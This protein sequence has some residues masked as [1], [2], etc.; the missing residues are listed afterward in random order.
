MLL[1]GF[2]TL[3][4]FLAVETLCDRLCLASSLVM[5]RYVDI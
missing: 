4:L 2:L 1:R 5:M 3:Y